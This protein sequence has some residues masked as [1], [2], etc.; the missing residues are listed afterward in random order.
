M[1]E[2]YVITLGTAGGPKLWT[3]ASERTGIATAVVVGEKFYLVDAGYG[4][5]RQIQRAGLE[6]ENLEGV[7]VTHMHSDHTVDLPA[8]MIFGLYQFLDRVD[9]PI[10]VIGPGER[11]KL[12]EVSPHAE[13]PPTPAAPDRRRRSCAGP[14]TGR[15]AAPRRSARSPTRRRTPPP[16]ARRRTRRRAGPRDR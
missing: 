8:L 13:T 5:G 6:F 10:P 4:A 16:C 15:T 14:R 3:D 2:P 11:G 7:F 9:R 12:P 1:R